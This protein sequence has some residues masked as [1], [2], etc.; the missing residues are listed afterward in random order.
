MAA[1]AGPTTAAAFA[2]GRDWHALVPAAVLTG[3]LGFGIGT[4]AGL[5][6]FALVQG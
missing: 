1:V 3:V 4:L 2:A 6:V 5:A